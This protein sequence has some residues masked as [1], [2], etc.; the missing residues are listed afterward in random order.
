[1]AT[2]AVVELAKLQV[3][4]SI[5]TKTFAFADSPKGTPDANAYN[6]QSQMRTRQP[7]GEELLGEA[8]KAR[9]L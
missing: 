7:S 2:A 8:R 3:P 1:M 4:K 6:K 9:R 5:Q